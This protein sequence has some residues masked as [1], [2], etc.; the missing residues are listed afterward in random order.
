MSGESSDVGM[1][2]ERGFGGLGG[3]TRI[4]IR[5]RIRLIRVK[6]AVYS[7]SHLHAIFAIAE[8]GNDF[9]LELRAISKRF[10]P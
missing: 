4:I 8:Q 9:M 5:A 7:N 10:A 2:I 6:S 3:F 1:G